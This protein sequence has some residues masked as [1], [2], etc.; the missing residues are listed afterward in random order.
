MAEILLG[1]PLKVV[2]EVDLVKPLSNLTSSKSYP[3]SVT[4]SLVMLQS[5]RTRMVATIRDKECTLEALQ[6]MQNYFDQLGNLEN[7]I[8]FSEAKIYFKWLNAFDRQG[9]L[10]GLTSTTTAYTMSTNLLYEK[11][12]VL[13][14]IAALSSL[15]ASSQRLDS[16]EGLKTATMQFQNAAGVFSALSVPLPQGSTE[17]K[18]TEDLMP[19]CLEA[20]SCLCLAQAQQCLVLK[21]TKDSKKDAIVA[22]LAAHA[23]DLFGKAREKMESE[24][25]RGLW[26][27]EW[28]ATVTSKHALYSGLTQLHQAGVCQEQGKIGE[29]IARLQKAKE[30]LSGHPELHTRA[31]ALLKEAVKDNEFIY[32]ERIPEAEVL[33]LIV[34]AALVKASPLPSKFL[35]GEKDLFSEM[36][37]WGEIKMKK[38]ECCVS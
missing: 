12:C 9:W 17:Q 36:P 33:E 13:F 29:K 7:K 11:A 5:L 22:K 21:A 35:P 10:G 32:H 24:K 25:V 20:L 28:T 16:E 23:R 2:G 1:V 18:P 27:R 3:P 8:P 6:H 30:F 4:E 19:E 34:P 31:E 26:E 38:E 37:A 15:L 14:N